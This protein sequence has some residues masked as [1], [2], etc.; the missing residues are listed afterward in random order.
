VRLI[1]F[2]GD[3]NVEFEIGSSLV[4]GHRDSWLEVTV[5]IEYELVIQDSSLHHLLQQQGTSLTDMRRLAGE[6]A[7]V[8]GLA[9]A[10]Q[11]QRGE[12]QNLQASLQRLE[13]GIDQLA[14]RSLW[15]VVRRIIKR[16]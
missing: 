2:D 14:K 11:Q 12:M 9:H 7:D 6:R 8:Q 4:E 15:S 13:Q 10:F 3:P 5:R 16:G 1:S